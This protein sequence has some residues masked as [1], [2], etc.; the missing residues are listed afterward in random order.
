MKNYTKDK[1]PRIKDGMGKEIEL[2]IP[3]SVS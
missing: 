3:Q 1:Y 2:I